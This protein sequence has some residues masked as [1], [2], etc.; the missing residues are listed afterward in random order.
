MF[1]GILKTV[2]EALASK[3][4]GEHIAKSQPFLHHIGILTQLFFLSLFQDHSY[5]GQV[6]LL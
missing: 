3:V 4:I 5:I 2:V 1:T 6:P